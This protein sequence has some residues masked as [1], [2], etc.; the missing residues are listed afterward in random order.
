MD[1]LDYLVI[2]EEKARRSINAGKSVKKT[3]NR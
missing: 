1:K 2:L 3:S